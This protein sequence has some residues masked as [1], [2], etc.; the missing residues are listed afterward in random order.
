[1]GFV[2]NNRLIIDHESQGFKTIRTWYSGRHSLVRLK[3]PEL[4]SYK[5][6]SCFSPSMGV[7]LGYSKAISY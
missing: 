7:F 2:V 4:K 3:R 5:L 6:L 1:M